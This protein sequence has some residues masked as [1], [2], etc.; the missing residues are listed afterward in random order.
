MTKNNKGT[1]NLKRIGGY[2]CGNYLVEINDIPNE[3][4][5]KKSKPSMKSKPCMK[6]LFI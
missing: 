2:T 6:K 1:D 5:E 3:G 4:V